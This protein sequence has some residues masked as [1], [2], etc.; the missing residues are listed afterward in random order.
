MNV[1]QRHKD[2]KQRRR[3]LRN[4]LANNAITFIIMHESSLHSETPPPGNMTHS[5]LQILSAV[6]LNDFLFFIPR[7]VR[8][9]VNPNRV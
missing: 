5:A 7:L 3:V 8:Y 2:N 1:R 6:D 4:D 9:P